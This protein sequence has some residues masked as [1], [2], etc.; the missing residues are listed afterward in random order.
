ML[1]SIWDELLLIWFHAR[2]NLGIYVA[3]N[4]CH[5]LVRWAG[6]WFYTSLWCSVEFHVSMDGDG[7]GS[8]V[9]IWR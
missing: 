3:I 1:L 8:E 4:A 5:G 6:F 7:L 2:S 9:H